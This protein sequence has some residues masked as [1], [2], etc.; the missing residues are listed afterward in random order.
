MAAP[1]EVDG[2][3]RR[4]GDRT[5][6]VKRLPGRRRQLDEQCLSLAS[7]A[8]RR[9]RRRTATRARSTPSQSR[10]RATPGGRFR[11]GHVG[12][13][14][15]HA[16][17]RPSSCRGGLRFDAG[18]GSGRPRRHRWERLGCRRRRPAPRDRV[19]GVW[20]DGLLGA[21]RGSTTSGSPRTWL[22]DD[23]DDLGD[24]PNVGSTSGPSRT[25][26]TSTTLR[27]WAPRR[28]G[29]WD[30]RGLG[31]ARVQRRSG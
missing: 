3:R 21:E 10:W 4:P 2:R 9:R 18:V 20:P 24:V 31:R 30:R 8:R 27:T 12:E 17:L 19:V 7:R 15:L 28:P 11:A 25:G 16:N 22:L 6:R 29:L 23:R 5:N 13:G 1:H 26:S 14:G